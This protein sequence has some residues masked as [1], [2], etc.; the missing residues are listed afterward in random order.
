MIRSSVLQA[1]PGVVHGFT[2]RA[3]HV[4]APPPE[5][6]QPAQL[7]PVLAELGVSGARVAMLAQVHGAQVHHAT[8]DG[9]RWPVAHGDALVSVSR[10][11]VVYVRVAD[12]VPVLVAGSRGVAAIHAGW[13]GSAAGVVQA[14]VERLV[15]ASGHGPRELSAAVGPSVGPCCYEVGPEVVEALARRAPLELFL[16]PRTGRRPTVD[17]GAVAVHALRELGIESVERLPGC[18]CCDPRFH[19]YRREG[20]QAGRQAA[21]VGLAL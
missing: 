7:D 1:V 14:G 8:L 17:V 19:S 6:S 13:R 10:G 9:P 16:H 5:A 15:E 12:C 18:T 4:P 2:T 3:W 20:A 21:F 11:L